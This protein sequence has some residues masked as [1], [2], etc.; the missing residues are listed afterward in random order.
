MND[1]EL[2][3]RLRRG[4]PEAVQALRFSAAAVKQLAVALV[5]V[6]AQHP[7]DT[8]GLATTVANLIESSS[9]SPSEVTGLFVELGRLSGCLAKQLARANGQTIDEA[10]HELGL[11]TAESA[12]YIRADDGNPLDNLPPNWPPRP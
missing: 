9:L 3:A 10:L 11:T 7:A 4:D 2:L 5:V 8:P 12:E 1:D 6:S